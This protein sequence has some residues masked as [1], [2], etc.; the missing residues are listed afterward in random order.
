M[1]AFS[2]EH[3][4]QFL[5]SSFTRSWMHFWLKAE[6]ETLTTAVISECQ[7]P[8]HSQRQRFTSYLKQI[9]TL[10]P[11]ICPNYWTFLAGANKSPYSPI[12]PGERKSLVLILSQFWTATICETE[13]PFVA[14]GNHF[15]PSSI[16]KVKAALCVHSQWQK[17]IIAKFGQQEH[18]SLIQSFMNS[19][20]QLLIRKS[21]CISFLYLCIPSPTIYC[22]KGML[23]AV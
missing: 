18:V 9:R 1:E 14:G 19:K 11:E 17:I 12:F 10:T 15:A 16:F 3:T 2:G 4:L 22:C 8:L 6:T 5:D 20:H 23:V 7:E 21:L 13:K